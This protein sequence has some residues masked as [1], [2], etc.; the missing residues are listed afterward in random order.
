MT[1]NRRYYWLKLNENFFEDDT[2]QWLEE[3]K[4]GKNYVIFYLKM[5]LKSL[6][7]DGSLIR[8]VGERLIPYDV[9]ALA[10]L[11][12][13]NE[14]TVAVAMKT[15]VDIGLVEQVETG[16]IYMT[17]I[18]E[19]IGTETDAARR[20]RRQRAKEAQLHTNEQLKI[21]S[22]DNVTG[23]SREGHTEIELEKEIDI[24]L[25]TDEEKESKKVVVVDYKMVN[26]FYQNNF[27]ILTPFLA[28]NL[29]YWC[30][31]VGADMVLEA[32]KIANKS[33]KPFTYAEGIMKNWERTN[34]KTLEDVK[35]NEVARSKQKPN[36]HRPNIKEAKLPDWAQDDYKRDVLD[37]AI[38]PRQDLK[39]RLER[40]RKMRNTNT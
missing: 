39:D 37:E 7:D 36:Y 33:Q 26:D 32:M 27:G 21:D 13:T 35:A 1:Q 17:Q 6:K 29:K 24:E 25:E 22:R 18:N 38:E 2:I 12:N 40:L 14:D 10:K 31:D 23:M 9:A 19:M 3:Q 8:Y 30:E 4:N 16:E 15:F 28:E 34:I 11:T 20:K 5:M